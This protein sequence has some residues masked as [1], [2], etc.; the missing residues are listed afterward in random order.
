MASEWFYQSM[1]EEFGPV[2]G[3]EVRKLTHDGA[4]S[5]DTRVKNAP[6]RTWSRKA[7]PLSSA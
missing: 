2:S 7:T 1:G 3:A 5:T 4:I 6:G